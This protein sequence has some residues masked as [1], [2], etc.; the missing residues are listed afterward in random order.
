MKII[1]NSKAHWQGDITSGKGQIEFGSKAYIGPY[2]FKDRFEE[3]NA[4]NPEELIAAA[5]AGCFSMALSGE[6]TKNGYKGIDINT[7]AYVELG[8]DKNG[9]VITSISL[10]AEVSVQD[11]DNTKLNEI[12]S[13]AKHNCPISKAL[14]ALPISLILN[15][16]ELQ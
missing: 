13:S 11:I 8:K 12:A 7:Q 16:T 1:R 2:S 4:T 15:G 6:L 14:S 5:H 10:K 9:F 3:G